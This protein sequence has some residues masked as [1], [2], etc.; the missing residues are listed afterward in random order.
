MDVLV[1][2]DSRLAR[3]ELVEQLNHISGASLV[4]E[5][6]NIRQAK[7]QIESLKP[8]VVLLDINMPGGDGLELLAKIKA[9]APLMITMP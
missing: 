3:L 7:Q 6:A 8:D 9:R 5:A 4:G 1:V 2:D